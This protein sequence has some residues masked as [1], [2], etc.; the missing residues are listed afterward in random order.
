[1]GVDIFRKYIWFVSVI[2]R[3]NGITLKELND[4]YKE[5]GSISNGENFN[6]RTFHRWREKIYEIFGIDIV[7]DK[8]R[9]YIDN[10]DDLKG[11]N[12]RLWL[13][14]TIATHNLIAENYSLK[15]RIILE[16][17]PSSENLRMIL[18]SMKNSTKIDIHYKKF[19][20]EK[21]K[22]LRLQPYCVKSFHRRWYML[23]KRESGELK[24]YALDRITDIKNTDIKF[25]IDKDFYAKDYFYESFGIYADKNIKAQNIEIKVFGEEVKYFRT[26][27]LHHSQK[28]TETKEDYSVF[29]YY[30]SPSYD[31]VMELLSYN[32]TIEVLS[33]ESLR[34]EIKNRLETSLNRYKSQ[35]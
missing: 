21:E 14:E 13:M 18:N 12:T 32:N 25:E 24:T 11:N 22:S 35:N 23:A 5:N 16:S 2:N 7:C 3:Y 26:L 19:S 15:D 6:E 20:D 28:E 31:F 9:Y 29:S 30:L 33:P 8:N 17:Q 4:L 10:K 1:M 34:Q 27:P